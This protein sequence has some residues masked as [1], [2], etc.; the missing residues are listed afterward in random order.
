M[1]SGSTSLA[2]LGQELRSLNGEKCR[3]EGH[4][5]QRKRKESEV[6]G[7]ASAVLP[8]SFRASQQHFPQPAASTPLADRVSSNNA[9]WG[10]QALDDPHLIYM[11]TVS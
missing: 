1:T 4:G 9:A 10:C 7:C 2:G 8:G 3:T 11:Q 5:L 6:Q